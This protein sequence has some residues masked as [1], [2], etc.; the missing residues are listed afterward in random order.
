MKL[1]LKKQLIKIFNNFLTTY[2]QN[3]GGYNGTKRN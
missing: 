3:S 1:R 2:A